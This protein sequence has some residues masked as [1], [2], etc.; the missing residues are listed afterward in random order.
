MNMNIVEDDIEDEETDEAA[1]FYNQGI[2]N[3]E[4]HDAATLAHTKR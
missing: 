4:D 1:M 3:F 2:K